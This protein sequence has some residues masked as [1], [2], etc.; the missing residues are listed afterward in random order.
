MADFKYDL[1]DLSTEKVDF[2]ALAF[3]LDISSGGDSFG[4][5]VRSGN[6]LHYCVVPID[7]RSTDTEKYAD[8][9][10]V[11]ELAEKDYNY[12]NKG[13]EVNLLGMVF[14]SRHIYIE[15]VS[16]DG[17]LIDAVRISSIESLPDEYIP[18]EHLNFFNDKGNA[19]PQDK[20]AE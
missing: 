17:R 3:P 12:F 9:Y 4:I 20:N 14:G 7:E 13:Y 1:K 8:R 2:D 11:C 16:V 10:L 15:D 5:T 18:S 19:E 6:G